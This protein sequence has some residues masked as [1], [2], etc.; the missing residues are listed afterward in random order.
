VIE[1]MPYPLEGPRDSTGHLTHASL[2]MEIASLSAIDKD[3]W[4]SYSN[5]STN[6]NFGYL[7]VIIFQK[8]R[9]ERICVQPQELTLGQA[10]ACAARRLTAKS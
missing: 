2:Q 1:N 4:A 5:G 8:L 10:G 9:T 6:K 3:D 7:I